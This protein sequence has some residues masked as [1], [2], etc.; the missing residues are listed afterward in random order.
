MEEFETVR[1][2]GNDPARRNVMLPGED[3]WDIGLGATLALPNAPMG[4]V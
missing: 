3:G 2:F 4:P 1:P